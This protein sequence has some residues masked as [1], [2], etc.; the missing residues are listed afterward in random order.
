MTVEELAHRRRFVD[1]IRAEGFLHLDAVEAALLTVDRSAFAPGRPLSEVYGSGSV[2][3]ETDAD[4]RGTS[5]VSAGWLQAVMLEASGLRPGMRVVEVGS[6]GYNASLLSQVVGAAGEVVS[7]D[8]SGSVLERARAGMSSQVRP[9]EN[10]VLL[11][12]DAWAPDVPDPGPIDSLVV[13]VDVWDLPWALVDRVHEGGTVVVP[14]RLDG[15]GVCLGLTKRG[16]ALVGGIATAAGFVPATGQGSHAANYVWD[17]A[18]ATA[19]SSSCSLPLSSDQLDDVLSRGREVVRTGVLVEDVA[20]AELF[21]WL[22]SHGGSTALWGTGSGARVD[23]FTALSPRGTPAYLA[24]GRGFATLA[25]DKQGGP[26]FELTVAVYGDAGA[27]ALE[28]VRVVRE[29]E[30][31]AERASGVDVRLRARS[32][33]DPS[34]AAPERTSVGWARV[35]D[36]SFEL[37]EGRPGTVV[38][39]GWGPT[40]VAG[41][42]A[43]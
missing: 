13:T 21:L 32:D 29:W 38:H 18:H 36:G 22:L 28:M 25:V 16:R 17:R 4:G 20:V 8:I 2:V 12:A 10:V 33:A 26:P 5:A 31:W 30:A 19:L 1:T 11:R 15:L 14:M 9:P 7:V 35:P 3:T 6:G 23:G 39:V 43:D 24:P 40:A 37:D 34:P 41:A 27:E 42:A